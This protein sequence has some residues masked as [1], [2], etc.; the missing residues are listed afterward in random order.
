MRTVVGEDGGVTQDVW[1]FRVT[2]VEGEQG[3]HSS[4]FDIYSGY[5]SC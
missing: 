4:V 1:E 2:K 5:G 3:L